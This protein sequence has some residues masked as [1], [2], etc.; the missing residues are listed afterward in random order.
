MN[1][2]EKKKNAA[3]AIEAFAQVRSQLTSQDKARS[4]DKLRLV[5]AGTFL[6]P[7]CAVTAQVMQVVRWL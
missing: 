5:L 6:H 2:F 4:L 3:L 7:M 1:R